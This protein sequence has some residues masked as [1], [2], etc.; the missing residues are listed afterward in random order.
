[1]HLMQEYSYGRYEAY[2]CDGEMFQLVDKK[3]LSDKLCRSISISSSHSANQKIDEAVGL[4][5]LTRGE[6]GFGPHGRK[7]YIYLSAEQWSKLNRL[8]ELFIQID[9]VVE[10]QIGA[11][12]ERG[13]GSALVPQEV[14]YDIKLDDGF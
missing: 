6:Q 3:T 7:S 1:M 13:A 10:V 11:P 12:D 14:Y 5:M 4:G 2:E 9:K 8:L